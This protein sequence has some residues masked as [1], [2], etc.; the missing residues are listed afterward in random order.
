MGI[1]QDENGELLTRTSDLL[2]FNATYTWMAWVDCSSAAASPELFTISNTDGSQ[3]DTV[4]FQSSNV[5]VLGTQT[6]QDNYSAASNTGINHVAMVRE[7]PTS[8]KLYWNGALVT[9]RTVNVGTGRTL[10]QMTYG[11]FPGVT[12][13]W[14][15]GVL[16][17][18]KAWT[19]AL[20][21]AEVLSEM[22]TI[23][24]RQMG[25]LYECWPA[26]SGANRNKGILRA[27][28]WTEVGT[29]SD[30]VSPPVSWGAGPILIGGLAAALLVQEGFRWY[31]DNGSESGSTAQA[32]QDTSITLAADTPTRLRVLIDATGNPPAT[33]FK[34]QY[35]RVGG[36]SWKD[37]T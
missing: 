16:G 33:L 28:D 29:L 20:T 26:F 14:W 1:V 2:D 21:A 17:S 22:R 6:G 25:S 7:S 30:G 3:Y 11:G 37:V 24:P 36:S 8:L 23:L 9:T 34:L 31:A 18:S 4:W 27:R 15:R 12:T 35:R 5:V 32:T 19:R 10:N 13:L